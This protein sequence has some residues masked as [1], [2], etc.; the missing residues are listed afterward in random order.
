MLP[1]LGSMAAGLQRINLSAHRYRGRTTSALWSDSRGR[2]R[3]WRHE[4]PPARHVC[5]PTRYGYT[6]YGLGRRRF[7]LNH[8]PVAP[9]AAAARSSQS[10]GVIV[11]CLPTE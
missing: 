8:N 7:Q 11:L 10:I 5:L 2:I 6:G 1:L 4:Y 3:Y 9:M